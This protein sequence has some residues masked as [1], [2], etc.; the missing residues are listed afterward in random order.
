MCVNFLTIVTIIYESNGVIRFT[1]KSH[2]SSDTNI[3]LNP[4][5]MVD[6]ARLNGNKRLYVQLEISNNFKCRLKYVLGCR[7]KCWV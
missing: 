2:A 5:D 1:I 4:F 7:D 3:T 6:I